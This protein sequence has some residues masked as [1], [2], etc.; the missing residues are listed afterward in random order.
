MRANDRRFMLQDLMYISVLEK[1]VLLGVDMLPRMEGDNLMLYLIHHSGFV[2]RASERDRD[3]F[4]SFN[5]R[6][7]FHRGIG[8]GAGARS[9]RDGTDSACLCK[10]KVE[11][12]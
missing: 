11:T 12:E 6:S 2:C 8:V 1:F 3:Q 4:G 10:C 9:G 5:S 7:A